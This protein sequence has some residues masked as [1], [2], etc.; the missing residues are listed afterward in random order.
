MLDQL[1]ATN[2]GVTPF[3]M[4]IPLQLIV[5]NIT[6]ETLF[7]YHYK[8]SDTSKYLFFT[9]LLNRHFQLAKDNFWVL[10]VQS[11]PW[12]RHLPIIDRKDTRSWLTTSPSTKPS[13][14]V[15]STGWRKPTTRARNP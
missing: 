12:T 9:G 8:Y 3:D 2:D 1:E 15:K 4:N 7:G 5:G 10:V 13:S 11:W 6:N 14:S